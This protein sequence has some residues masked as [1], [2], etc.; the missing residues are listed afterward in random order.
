MNE[1]KK[2]LISQEIKN[3]KIKNDIFSLDNEEDN[4]NIITKSLFN[5]KKYYKPINE[6]N[7]DENDL[8]K[9]I[10]DLNKSVMNKSQ[11][12]NIEEN[13]DKKSYNSNSSIE[14]LCPKDNNIYLKPY[15]WDIY[16]VDDKNINKIIKEIIKNE[17]IIEFKKNLEKMN[18]TSPE[19]DEI[20]LFSN[21]GY[22]NIIN[23][24]NEICT[25]KKN[26]KKIIYRKIKGDGNCFYRSVIFAL[27]ENL[28]L[29]KDIIFIKKIFLNFIKKSENK[30]LLT[31]FKGLNIDI[32]L[33]KKCFIMIYLSLI[34]KCH[35][36]ILKTFLVFIKLINNYK[37]F[38]Y[39][40]ILFFK[41]ILYEYINNNKSCTYSYKFQV[42]LGNLLPNDCQNDKGVFD[43]N[44]FYR[45]YLM[46]FYQYAEK[47][48]IYLT[49]FIFGKELIIKYININE[50]ENESD[51]LDN[52]EIKFGNNISIIE[53]D[54]KNKIQLIYKKSHYDILYSNEYYNNNKN[55]LKYS[56]LKYINN[57]YFGICQICKKN[58]EKKSVLI[59]LES[60]IKSEDNFNINKEIIICYKCLYNE[61]KQ[62]LIILYKNF[63]KKI[64]KYFLNNISEKTS[65]FLTKDFS[66]LNN[67]FNISF[68]QAIKTL[69]LYKNK[70]SFNYIIKQ[71]KE[72]ICINC[73][74]NINN[75]NK[76][77]LINLS[78]NC[79]LCSEKCVKEFYYILISS[80]YI[81]QKFICFCNNELN[82]EQSLLFIEKLNEKKFDCKEMIEVLFNNI[83]KNICFLCL[84]QIKKEIKECNLI[85]P[86]FCLNRIIKHFICFNCENKNNIFIGQ[87]IQCL[88]CKRNHIVEKNYDVIKEYNSKGYNF[89]NRDIKNN[90]NKN[91]SEI[92]SVNDINNNK[93]NINEEEKITFIKINKK[94]K[95][96]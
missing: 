53:F 86:N 77:K 72:E 42:L 12:I 73:T 88:I 79:F 47:I 7:N 44:F 67:T 82:I 17:E 35:N 6:I 22:I 78:C 19:C 34:S 83:Y 55:I 61:I 85:E 13:D 48:I 52:Q 81:K 28:I 95:N 87:N 38:D 21:I 27:I 90:K 18:L 69:E 3:K 31:M 8:I 23:N 94:K 93:I 39:G 5:I 20:I 41:F 58:N 32:N 2:I 66:L 25:T 40:L 71:I 59:K 70:Y 62:N 96:K 54:T 80:A 4:L 57:F 51:E 14:S 74:N 84:N 65:D 15:D 91:K 30:I 49:P 75:I 64:K 10:N 60:D 37:D 43:F 11:K 36:P 68:N 33:C 29:N 50:N 1:N 76:K 45:N 56:L 9:E 89:E 24:E 16:L 26:K 63:I 46:K 92:K